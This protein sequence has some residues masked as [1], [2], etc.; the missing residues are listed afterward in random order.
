MTNKKQTYNLENLAVSNL[1]VNSTISDF[2]S[3]SQTAS[4]LYIS[5]KKEMDQKKK[6]I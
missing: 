4:T 6:G 5:Q 3:S 2:S 1:E